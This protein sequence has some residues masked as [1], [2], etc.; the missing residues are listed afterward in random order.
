MWYMINDMIVPGSSYWNVALARDVGAVSD[1]LEA[2]RTID[3][4][5]DNLAWLAEK[6][7]GR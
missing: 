1:D 4:F 6:T 7:L 5:A 2:L 3:R